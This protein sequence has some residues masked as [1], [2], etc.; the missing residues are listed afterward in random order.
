MSW[1]AIGI[2]DSGVGGLTVLRE[3]MK[4]LPQEDTIYFGDTARVPY[5]TKSPDTVIRYAREIATFLTRRDI[6][7]LV[8]AC[9]TASAVALPALQE[10][11]S[12]PVVGVI[13]P[14]ATRAV[15]ATRSGKIG[16]I[17]TSGT[18]RSSAYTRAIKRL[19]PEVEVLA[20]PCPIFVPLAEEGWVDNDIAYRTAELYLH[21]LQEAGVDT[22]VLGC[23]HYPLLKKVIGTIM[24][25]DVV[26]VDSAEETAR[27]V[28]AIL[29][30]QDMLRPVTESG[31]H[32]YFVT[33]VPAGFIRVG[34]RFLGGKLGDVYQVSL[35]DCKPS[36]EDH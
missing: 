21:D 24:G 30:E 23:T 14:G 28:A 34:N 17:G 27:T 2:F 15:E 33:D 5:G 35:E 19:N 10:Q 18:I 3:L 20:T 13:E 6:K 25:P 12:I 31:N 29:A 11:L 36:P 8:V 26:L 16:V 7:L 22:L 1:Q 32:H 9:N 4:V